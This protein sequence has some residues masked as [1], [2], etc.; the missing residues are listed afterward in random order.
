MLAFESPGPFCFASSHPFNDDVFSVWTFRISSYECSDIPKLWDDCF[1]PGY[2]LKPNLEHCNNCAMS[3]NNQRRSSRR[4]G[5]PT[6]M[7]ARRRFPPSLVA[8]IGNVLNPQRRTVTIET[9]WTGYIPAGSLTAS[10]NFA[11]VGI[12]SLYLPFST[13]SGNTVVNVL[14]ATPFNGVSVAG[15]AIS[16]NPIGYNF[17]SS[18]YNGYKVMDYEVELTVTPQNSGD[19]IAV[20][21]APLGN[22]EQPTTGNWTYYRMAA[23]QFAQ[24]GRAINGANSRLNTLTYSGAVHRD[25]GLTRA[26]WTAFGGITAMGSQVGSNQYDYLGVFLCTLDGAATASIVCVDI[27]IRQRV[28]VSDPVQYGN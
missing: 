4:R 10:G 5:R 28:T 2:Q 13:A 1:L 26:Q 20:S 19:T 17:L 11:S 14:G 18:N 8:N 24:S 27:T 25:L 23:Q 15:A 7:V 12:N 6:A 22:Q 16:S 3:V 9:Q 21:M